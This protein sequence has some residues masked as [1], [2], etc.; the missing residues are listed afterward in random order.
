MS[1]QEYSLFVLRTPD[2]DS[3][4]LQSRVASVIRAFDAPSYNV[5]LDWS[6]QGQSDE[7]L[8][9]Q[10]LSPLQ[11]VDLRARLMTLGFRVRVTPFLPVDAM[12]A[13]DTEAKGDLLYWVQHVTGF[14][15]EWLHQRLSTQSVLL[16]HAMHPD[17]AVFLR[18]QLEALG[19][20]VWTSL[21]HSFEVSLVLDSFGE[22]KIQVIKLVREILGL[23]LRETKELVESA[24]CVIRSGLYLEEAIALQGRFA[25]TGATASI[26]MGQGV[27]ALQTKNFSSR[28]KMRLESVPRDAVLRVAKV[29]QEQLKLSLQ[30]AS[31]VLDSLPLELVCQGEYGEVLESTNRLRRLGAGVS[32]YQ[33]HVNMVAH[34]TKPTEGS[35]HY[36]VVVVDAGFHPHETTNTLR[37]LTS[38]RWSTAEEQLADLPLVLERELPREEAERWVGELTKAGATAYLR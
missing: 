13:K 29:L 2:V 10:T 32:L 15:Q 38:V 4:L 35:L 16:G 23:G 19:G 25:E 5:L 9:L 31:R 18:K 3:L 36:D 8:L 33:N 22:R 28:W 26:S 12:V 1:Q 6:R 7:C 34:K 30:A 20:R 11:L 24:P 37:D 21:E 14:G 17:R 27:A